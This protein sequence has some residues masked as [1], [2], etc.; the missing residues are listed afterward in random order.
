[1]VAGNQ[2]VTAKK[3]F[4]FPSLDLDCIATPPS[5]HPNFENGSARLFEHYR[6]VEDCPLLVHLEFEE[7]R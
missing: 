4:H 1:M 6:T 3:F 7:G 2:P 5:Y